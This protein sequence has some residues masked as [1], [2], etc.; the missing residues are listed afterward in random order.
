VTLT[1]EQQDEVQRHLQRLNPGGLYARA[2]DSS[3]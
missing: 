2:H 3:N 1:A